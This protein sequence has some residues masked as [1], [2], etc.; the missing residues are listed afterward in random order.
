[1]YMN[2]DSVDFDRCDILL[3]QGLCDGDE[4]LLP[5]AAVY[6][7]INSPDANARAD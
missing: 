7:Y 1:M 5:V 2:I 6:Q 4:S 3:H